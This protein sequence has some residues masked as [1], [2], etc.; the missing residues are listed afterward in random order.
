MA[1]QDSFAHCL[2]QVRQPS[3]RTS[4]CIPHFS[5]EM[6]SALCGRNVLISSGSADLQQ[7]SGRCRRIVGQV[8][9]QI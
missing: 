8:G 7:G 2:L 6:R 5:R 1:S 3:L 9:R 4:P